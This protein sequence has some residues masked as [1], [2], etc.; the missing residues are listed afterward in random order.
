M[1]ITVMISITWQSIMWISEWDHEILLM[2][3]SQA[4][5]RFQIYSTKIFSEI[6]SLI[7]KIILHLMSL[8]AEQHKLMI[9]R[10]ES[11][12]IHRTDSNYTS[13]KHHF[14]MLSSKKMRRLKFK[15]NEFYITAQSV[16]QISWHSR[17]V[18]KAV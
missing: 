9:F 1:S 17:S 15:V 16:R 5:F 3:Q 8:L 18:N 6:F 7:N 10:S 14:S 13:T 11:N 2:K 4:C 12:V